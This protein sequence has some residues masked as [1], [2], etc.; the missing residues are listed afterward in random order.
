[1]LAHYLDL[2]YT[3]E[4]IS[5]HDAALNFR[6][7]KLLDADDL[8]YQLADSTFGPNPTTDLTLAEWF[9]DGWI[10][11]DG[12]INWKFN[13]DEHYLHTCTPED[14]RCMADLLIRI[15]TEGYKQLKVDYYL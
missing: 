1:M 4:Y 11:F 7:Y 12:C 8:T 10:K 5:P 3:V 6:A 15:Q 2:G 13:T 9:V 14:V